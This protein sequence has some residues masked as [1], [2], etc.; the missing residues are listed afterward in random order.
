MV[1]NLLVV[2]STFTV[3]ASELERGCAPIA[4]TCVGKRYGLLTLMRSYVVRQ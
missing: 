2:V 4:A 3:L 1:V